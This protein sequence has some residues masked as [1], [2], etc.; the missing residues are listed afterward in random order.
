M[1]VMGYK[2]QSSSFIDTKNDNA[3][4]NI[5]SSALNFSYHSVQLVLGVAIIS[6]ILY[7]FQ[8]TRRGNVILR[9]TITELLVFLT[10]FKDL[11]LMTNVD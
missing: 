5:F 9:C 4:L 1:T 10:F 8:W 3:K 7:D 6:L 2:H 11:I